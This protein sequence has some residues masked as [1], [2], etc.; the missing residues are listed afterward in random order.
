VLAAERFESKTFVINF[1]AVASGKLELFLMITSKALR[2]FGMPTTDIS[3]EIE[4]SIAW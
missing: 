3:P 1:V 2:L 4:I